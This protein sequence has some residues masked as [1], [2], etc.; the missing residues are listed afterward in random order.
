METS[1]ADTMSANPDSDVCLT[2]TTS[3]FPEPDAYN[4]NSS[5]LSS[6]AT[7]PYIPFFPQPRKKFIIR[8][9]KTGLL[10]ALKRGVLDLHFDP[11][12]VYDIP[13]RPIAHNTV[14]TG[15]ALKMRTCGSD[16]KMRS[17]E[18][19]L[20]AINNARHSFAK[21]APHRSWEQ[22]CVRQHPDGGHALLA[23]HKGGFRSM[24]VGGDGERLLIV[25]SKGDCGTAFEF[26]ELY[27]EN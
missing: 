6:N 4:H 20:G 5:N 11:T 16:S 19:I 24:R 27:S 8:E 13:G 23:R 10:I 17:Q 12:Q 7:V 3:V 22:F 1:A 2:P 21:A 9:S 26:I 14:A 15:A 25:G 18:H